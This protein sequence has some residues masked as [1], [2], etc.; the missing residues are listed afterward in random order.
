MKG[1]KCRVSLGSAQHHAER[2]SDGFRN[3]HAALAEQRLLT[4]VVLHH[5]VTV[6]QLAGLLQPLLFSMYVICTQ[7]RMTG[8]AQSNRYFIIIII[9]IIKLPN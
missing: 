7:Q 9:I 8:V 3:R 2:A 4:F 6:V 5:S 1:W